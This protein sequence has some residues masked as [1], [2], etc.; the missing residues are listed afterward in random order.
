MNAKNMFIVGW[1]I[2]AIAA[3][4]LILEYYT[5]APTFFLIG[6]V[7]AALFGLWRANRMKTRDLICL[8]TV[9][10]LI[11]LIDEYAHASSGVLTYFDH[12][13]P[14]LL[15]VMGWSLFV[16]LIFGI[17]EIMNRLPLLKELDKREAKRRP[18]TLAL[19]IR[20]IPALLAIVLL[21]ILAFAQGYLGVFSPL[22]AAVYVALGIT[23]LY[24][25]HLRTV[26]WNLS[27]LICSAFVGFV[28]EY[29]GGLEGMWW[30]YY[31]EPV[32]LFMMFTWALR[33]WAILSCCYFVGVRFEEVL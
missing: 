19:F 30:Y 8:V 31:L 9:S 7:V 2:T 15:T 13:T 1:V 10:I 16:L 6:L 32:P 29:V 3:S 18:S 5:L 24:Y 17:A 12:S 33:T 4:F 25:S 14:S 28:M 23:S 20:I 21:I 27:I 11:A 26:S 22:L